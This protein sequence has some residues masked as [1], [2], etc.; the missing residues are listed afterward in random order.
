MTFF[1]FF[2]S[3]FFSLGASITL[4][5]QGGYDYERYGGICLPCGCRFRETQH[6][7]GI[8]VGDILTFALFI[9]SYFP[10]CILWVGMGGVQN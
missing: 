2:F 3:L 5:G 1:F 8:G 9:M 10:V 6:H 7:F 4:S